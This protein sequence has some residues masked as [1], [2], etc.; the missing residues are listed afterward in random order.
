MQGWGPRTTG[1]THDVSADHSEHR[2]VSRPAAGVYQRYKTPFLETIVGAKSKEL[3]VR[4][5][6]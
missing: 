1:S 5:E 6:A 2:S 3:L 4:D